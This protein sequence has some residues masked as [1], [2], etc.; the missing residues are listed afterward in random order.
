T[1]YATRNTQYSSL[2]STSGFVGRQVELADVIRRLTDPD[3]RLLTLAGRQR[4]DS[5]GAAGSADISG[6]LDG[7][8]RSR[9]RRALRTAVRGQHAGRL[10]LRAGGSGAFR[11]LFQ[12]RATTAGARLLSGQA[13]ASGAR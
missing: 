9:R 10:D 4:Q 7:R 11:L 13:H 3:C 12:C 2:L 5:P 6:D 8:R 1:Q